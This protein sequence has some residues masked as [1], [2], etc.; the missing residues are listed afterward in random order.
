MRRETHSWWGLTWP[1]LPLIAVFVF[2]FTGTPFLKLQFTLSSVPA[3]ALEPLVGATS[4][5]RTIAFRFVE[6]VLDVIWNAERVA[7]ILL[8]IFLACLSRWP[9]QCP[10]A[11]VPSRRPWLVLGVGL[12]LC[13]MAVAGAQMGTYFRTGEFL[14]LGF[15]Q[16]AANP[17]MH[18][19]IAVL[20]AFYG[21]LIVAPISEEIVFRGWLQRLL[22]QVAGV[23][24]SVLL[25]GIAFGAI[26]AF[27]QGW[28]GFALTGFVGVLLGGIYLYSGR[29]WVCMI[30]HSL[31]NLFGS[32]GEL[33]W[34]WMG[35][36]AP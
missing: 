28:N 29:L 30:G 6:V 19:D 3:S 17:L 5:T 18:G 36:P 32:Y 9:W 27:E 7:G 15:A 22:S 21:I 14:D 34:L 16:P 24:P 25:Q 20:V 31:V 8:F 23:W 35:R 10:A 13:T 26:H 2:G 33:C 4:D 11:G 1:V 12:A